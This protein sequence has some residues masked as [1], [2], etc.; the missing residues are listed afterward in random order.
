MLALP[1]RA[2]CGCRPNPHGHLAG[3]VAGLAGWRK[4]CRDSMLVAKV[5]APSGYCWKVLGR[6]TQVTLCNKSF[7]WGL[8]GVSFHHPVPWQGCWQRV[9]TGQVLR[10]QQGTSTRT[11]NAPGP[12]SHGGRGS[13]PFPRQWHP[14]AMR[15]D[16]AALA[17]RLEVSKVVTPSSG[18][19]W[20]PAPH[21]IPRDAGSKD[22]SV[23]RWR[24]PRQACRGPSCWDRDHV[25]LEPAG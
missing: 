8:R 3:A 9:C 16:L 13:L 24:W 20:A 1:C 10:A 18:C 19:G 5:L 23:A 4:V 14:P 15:Q 25:V 17:E 7:L 11:V 12:L 2:G 22:A 21:L 6:V